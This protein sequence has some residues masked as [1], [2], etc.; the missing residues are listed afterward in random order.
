MELAKLDVFVYI[1]TLRSYI[2]RFDFKSYRAAHKPR[3]T[4]RHCKSMLHWAKETSIEPK[5]NRETLFT[6]QINGITLKKRQQLLRWSTSIDVSSALH[7]AES[8][9]D[10]VSEDSEGILAL[11]SGVSW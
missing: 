7:H 8:Q 5:T 10:Q 3:L 2:D 9:I 11:R 1:E 4:A 6:N